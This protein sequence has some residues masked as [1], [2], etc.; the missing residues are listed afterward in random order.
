MA[1]DAEVVWNVMESLLVG[2]WLSWKFQAVVE[3]K[4]PWRADIGPLSLC[5]LPWR[6]CLGFWMT[7]SFAFHRGSCMASGDHEIHTFF[8]LGFFFLFWLCICVFLL[9]V[10]FFFLTMLNGK[11]YFFIVN[12][13]FSFLP[14]NSL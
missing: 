5:L 1:L 9:R 2:G 11:I 13:D 14:F 3:G 8:Q 6:Q 12:T 7:I 4:G 10:G